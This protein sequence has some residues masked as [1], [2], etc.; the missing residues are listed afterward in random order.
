MSVVVKPTSRQQH[1][2]KARQELEDKTGNKVVSGDNYL[3]PGKQK[4]VRKKD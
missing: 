2:P 1:T 3:P 4:L